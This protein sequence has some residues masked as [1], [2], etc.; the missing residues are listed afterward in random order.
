MVNRPEIGDLLTKIY[1]DDLGH[2]PNKTCDTAAAYLRHARDWLAYCATRRLDPV[3]AEPAEISAF[4]YRAQIRAPDGSRRGPSQPTR[5][6][7]RIALKSFYDVLVAHRIVSSNPVVLVRSPRLD[8]H[9]AVG[10]RLE[11]AQIAALLAAARTFGPSHLAITRALYDMGLRG[12]E[13]A[14]ARLCDWQPHSTGGGM[15]RVKGRRH[16]DA[17]RPAPTATAAAIED[18]L[19][20]RRRVCPRHPLQRP[21]DPLFVLPRG[22]VYLHNAP[23]P[24]AADPLRSLIERLAVASGT[25][26]TTP[27]DARR[28]W[29]CDGLMAGYST[30]EIGRELGHRDEATT[31]RY[32]SGHTPPISAHATQI[33]ATATIVADG[34]LMYRAMHG[35]EVSPVAD[36][37]TAMAAR[38]EQARSESGLLREYAR[39][40]DELTAA[41]AEITHLRAALGVAS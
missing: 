32:A 25:P 17:N 33:R 30:T 12:V 14:R 6:N 8:R 28:S 31:A 39:T 7:R 13:I 23:Q 4:C 3:T 20:W 34:I 24:I 26:H 21:G 15:L 35:G 1:Q 11:P 2:D 40:R 36:A 19:E 27:R 18:A 41:L 5:R 10:P 22:P 16:L 38:H 9:I 37:I 29:V